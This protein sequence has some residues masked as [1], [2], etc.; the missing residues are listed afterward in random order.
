ML[1]VVSSGGHQASSGA[2]RVARKPVST[3]NRAIDPVHLRPAEAD[4]LVGGASKT[5]QKLGWKPKNFAE[6]VKELV[7]GDLAIARR[8][9][10]NGKNPV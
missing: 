3:G 10:A 4:L 6:R 5:R 7:A 1:S 9:A 8:E 2:A